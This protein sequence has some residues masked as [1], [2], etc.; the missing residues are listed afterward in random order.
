[1]FIKIGRV[2]LFTC[3]WYPNCHSSS[4]IFIFLSLISIHGSRVGISRV[5]RESGRA[6]GRGGV[7]SIIHFL[8]IFVYAF[9]TDKRNG[10]ESN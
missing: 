2:V 4:L 5:W 9:E 3:D 1:M 8:F 10:D 7:V 6:G